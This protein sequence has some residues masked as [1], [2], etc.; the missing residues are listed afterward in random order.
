MQAQYTVCY[1]SNH[2]TSTQKEI[3]ESLNY[4]IKNMV[5]K[6]EHD[7]LVKRFG[8]LEERFDGLEERFDGLEKRFDIMETKQIVMQQDIAKLQSSVQE[9]RN[10][11]NDA[12]G[13]LDGF[14]KK[15]DTEKMER[16][17]LHHKVDR[18]DI[19]IQDIAKKVD[20]HLS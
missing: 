3:R 6:A 9:I 17:A 11:V 2:N 12:F 8:G 1:M 13:T 16:T 20:V 10:T 18:H 14:L 15:L 4:I 5:T 19:W 7:M